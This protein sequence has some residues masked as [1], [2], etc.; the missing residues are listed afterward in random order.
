MKSTALF[1]S[2]VL[3]GAA[4]CGWQSVVANAW[5]SRALFAICFAVLAFL[6]GLGYGERSNRNYCRSVVDAN[7]KLGRENR[8]LQQAVEDGHARLP[9]DDDPLPLERPSAKSQE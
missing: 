4:V 2:L 9:S 1:A 3:V 7:L 5:P 8:R 6:L